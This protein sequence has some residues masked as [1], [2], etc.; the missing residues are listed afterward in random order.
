M[1]NPGRKRWK[2]SDWVVTVRQ[3]PCL[4]WAGLGWLVGLAGLAG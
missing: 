3:D 2:S 1:L 4:G